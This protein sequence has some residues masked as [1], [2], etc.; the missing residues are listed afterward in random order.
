MRLSNLGTIL[1]AAVCLHVSQGLLYG[2]APESF[3]N[4]IQ[5]AKYLQE[6]QQQ[7]KRLHDAAEQ[8]MYFQLLQSLNS[9]GS[10]NE[11]EI[12]STSLTS[13]RVSGQELKTSSN[14]LA[15]IRSS[16]I[17]PSPS[18]KYSFIGK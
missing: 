18:F 11:D 14:L 7:L 6:Q 8:Q 17:S 5:R 3:L 13:P 10:S 1:F 4:K 2:L 16:L 12:K 15:A 9:Q